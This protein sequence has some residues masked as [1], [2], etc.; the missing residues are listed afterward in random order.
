MRTCTPSPASYFRGNNYRLEDL[1]AGEHLR[2]V[3][4]NEVTNECQVLKKIVRLG[5]ALRSMIDRFVE[6]L[7]ESGKGFCVEL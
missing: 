1:S 7:F 4:Y 3:Q 2:A 6:F 5:G